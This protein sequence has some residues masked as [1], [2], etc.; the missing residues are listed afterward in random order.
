MLNR[1]ENR[2]EEETRDEQRQM[3]RASRLTAPFLVEHDEFADL[4]LL[5]GAEHRAIDRRHAVLEARVGIDVEAASELACHPRGEVDVL[6][7]EER[8]FDVEMHRR[9]NFA[10]ES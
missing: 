7:R 3:R 6:E 2:F 8:V 10:P 5:A 4:A 1:L 9:K